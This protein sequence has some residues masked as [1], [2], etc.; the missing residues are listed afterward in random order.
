MAPYRDITVGQLLSNLAQDL[1]EREGLVYPDRGLRMNFIELEERCNRMARA[2]LAFGVQHGDRV[3][4]WAP[5]LP[6]WIYLQFALAKLGAI[7]VTVNTSLQA[8]ELQYILEQSESSV[9][10]LAQGS[11]DLDFVEVAGRALESLETRPSLVLMDG[12]RRD[13]I[14]LL[15]D[16]EENLSSP[17]EL[18]I[19]S[20]S[21]TPDHV[22]NMQYTSGTTGFPKGVMLSSRNILNNAYWLGQGLGYTP[23][24]RLCLPVPLFHCFGCVI[25]VLGAYTHGACLVPLVAFDPLQVLECIQQERCTAVYGVPT[26]FLAVLEHPRFAEFEVASL[27]TGVMAGSLCPEALMLRVQH[28]LHVPEITIAYGL[29]ETSPAVT[30]TARDDT[31]ER[32]TQTVGRALPEVELKIV[33][34][35][36]GQTLDPGHPGELCARGYV[37]M[38][39]YYN[40]PEETARTIDEEGWLHSGDLATIDE[41]GYVRI[42]GRLKD[43]I[44]R[45]GENISPKEVEDVLREHPSVLDLCVF[46]IP[47]PKFGE[48]VAVALRL[49]EGVSELTRDELLEFAQGRIARFKVPRRLVFVDEFPLTASGKI[50][51]YR[52]REFYG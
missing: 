52:L 41:E 36:T 33:D 48:E 1:G 46:A 21:V 14:P 44:I 18:S 19:R 20:E 16:L 45:G 28:D 15:E 42:T 22:I 31:V 12:P 9:L 27:R 50:Q 38:Q 40:K 5:N 26:M 29:T 51:R 7:L 4:V 11:R 30:L 3:A 23:A 24:D 8:R 34:P 49:R 2:L 25:G 35:E 6:E 47:D 32:R 39:G 43:L 17:E 13:D 37:V 10:I